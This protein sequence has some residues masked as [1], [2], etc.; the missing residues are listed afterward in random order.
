[1]P[2]AGVNPW[3]AKPTIGFTASLDAGHQGLGLG[4]A[5]CWTTLVE[6]RCQPLDIGAYQVDS[7]SLSAAAIRG[8]HAPLRQR[9]MVS[10]R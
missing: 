8:C 6:I 7:N 3:A 10:M 1:M 5:G 9:M 4:Q 2:N